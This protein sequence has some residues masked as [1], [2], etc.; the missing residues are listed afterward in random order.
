M[1]LHTLYVYMIYRIELMIAFLWA[2]QVYKCLFFVSKIIIMELLTYNGIK[3][4]KQNK[5]IVSISTADV[6]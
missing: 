5:E 1:S 4:N 2:I 3:Q 6:N